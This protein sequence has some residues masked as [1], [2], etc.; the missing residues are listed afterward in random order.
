MH[1]ETFLSLDQLF[2]ISTLRTF[3]TEPLFAKQY[4]LE[5][6]DISLGLSWFSRDGIEDRIHSLFSV[7]LLHLFCPS[8]SVQ[9]S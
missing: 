4:K 3:L 2:P 5:N 1:G 8:P 6:S 7:G 9:T